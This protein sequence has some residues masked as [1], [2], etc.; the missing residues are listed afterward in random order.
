ID[1]IPATGTDCP[2]TDQRG[3]ARPVGPKC[4]IGAYELAGPKVVVNPPT[5]VTRT[6]ATLHGSVTPNAGIASA[7]FIYGPTT[8]YGSST[9]PEL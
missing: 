6:T 2:A 5:A 8:K 3:V 9:R 1:Q 7:H 4:D